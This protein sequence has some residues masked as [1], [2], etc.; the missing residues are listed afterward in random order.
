LQAMGADII[1]GVAVAR[2]E[3]GGVSLADGTRIPPHA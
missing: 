1:T 3:R 2:Y